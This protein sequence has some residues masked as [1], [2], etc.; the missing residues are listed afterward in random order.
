MNDSATFLANY[1]SWLGNYLW[2]VYGIVIV[3]I[4]A[5]VANLVLWIL[6]KSVFEDKDRDAT[7]PI[8]KLFS[9]IATILTIILI[10]MVFYSLAGLICA[11]VGII[12]PGTKY[13]PSVQY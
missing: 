4:I 11:Q 5:F 8:R 12:L 13:I 6:G 2:L 9:T 7:K 3:D 1:F 10:L